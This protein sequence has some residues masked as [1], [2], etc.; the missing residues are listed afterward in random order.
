MK[1]AR[2]PLTFASLAEVMPDVDRLLRGHTTLGNWS[3]GQI[4]SHLAQGIHFTIDGF[5]PEVRQPWIVRATVGRFLLWRILRSGRFLEG[6]RMPVKYEPT[7][8]TD[9]RA[10]AESLRSALGRLAAHTGPLADLPFRG[11]LS[12]DV[13]E[14]F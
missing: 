6:V 2:R 14:R 12:R 11:Q 5:P 9:A 7:P 4:C 8:G 10:E 13:W 3:L 1:A